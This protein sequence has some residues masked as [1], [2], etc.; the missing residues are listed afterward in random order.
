MWAIL[1]ARGEEKGSRKRGARSSTSAYGRRND[2]NEANDRRPNALDLNP[3]ARRRLDG[4]TDQSRSTQAARTRSQSETC[5]GL[6][7]AGVRISRRCG[8]EP[9]RA[10][11]V[12]KKG[13]A[14]SLGPARRVRSGLDQAVGRGGEGWAVRL[15]GFGARGGAGAPPARRPGTAAPGVAGPGGRC[16]RRGHPARPASRAEVSG[17]A[18]PRLGTLGPRLCRCPK[19]GE[20]RCG[21]FWAEGAL[22]YPS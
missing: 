17:H 12:R 15:R 1:P 9:G 11:E 2:S 13:G 19:Q 6:T 8:D 10:L 20:P 16:R 18:R 3:T 4:V 14:E 5:S 21:G 22:R 7:G